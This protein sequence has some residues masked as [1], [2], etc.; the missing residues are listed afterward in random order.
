MAALATEC[1]NAKVELINYGYMPNTHAR[2]LIVKSADVG[3][4]MGTS[5]L[6]VAGMGVPC[7]MIDPAFHARTKP[8]R[9]FHL[10]HEMQGYT[11]GEYRD[12]PGYQSY[13]RSFEECVDLALQPGVGALGQKYLRRHHDPA[14]VFQSTLR[15]IRSSRY[16]GE[17]LCRHVITIDESF[18]AMRR[19]YGWAGG[20]G[21]V[22][23]LRE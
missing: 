14:S 18:A 6:D 10:V 9:L 16:T 22:R 12:F 20:N 2:D 19:W 7:I 13:G 17:D 15:E 23:F 5:A 3:L 4:A 8:Q 11:L 1:R 21:K